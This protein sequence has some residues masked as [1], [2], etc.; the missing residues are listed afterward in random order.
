MSIKEIRDMSDFH[1]DLINY[2]EL[3][4]KL[5]IILNT[6]IE[7]GRKFDGWHAT[8]IRPELN[9]FSGYDTIQYTE[10]KR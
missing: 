2:E 5:N 10:V 8:Q 6:A 9:G 4:K 3:A 7:Y 1:D